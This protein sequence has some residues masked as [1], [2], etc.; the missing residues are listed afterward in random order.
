MYNGSFF[1]RECRSLTGETGPLRFRAGPG[2]Y[3]EIRQ[4][5]FAEE[6]IGTIAGAS[7]GAKWLVLSQLDRVITERVLPKLAGPVHL[8]GSSI[9]A[10]RFACYAQSAPLA[11]LERF[12]AAYVEQRY[13]ARPTAAEV[14]GKTREILAHV[15]GESGTAEI[16]SHAHFRS[17]I[18]TVRSRLLTSSDY[19][20]ALWS[21]LFAAALAN[22][23]S[24]RTLG[25]FFTRSLFYDPRDLPP[26]YNA[27]GFPLER[28]ALTADNL[29]DAVIA[30]GSIPTV[31]TGVRDIPGAP[32]GVYRDGGIIDYHLDLPL[33]EPDRLT[34]FPHFFDRLIPGWFDKG[35]RWRRHNPLHTDRTLLISPSA[36]FISRLP[37]GKVPD[38]TDF[39]RLTEPQRIDV[40]QRAI[41]A[42]REL[43]DD[44]NDVLDG[45]RLAAR[46]EPL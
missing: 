5:G 26:F 12:E 40:W 45:D 1:A 34:L 17:H 23:V 24:R 29:V 11:A 44:L 7:G 27:T 25:A 43:A 28:I 2:A 22:S 33:G 41:A 19:R 20:P 9:G 15:L 30:S 32:A 31:L 35:L 10:W 42:C 8:L 16:I 37:G 21:G 14:S 18:L 38:R 3:H 36:E 4:R 39:V 13:S 46:L 6:R